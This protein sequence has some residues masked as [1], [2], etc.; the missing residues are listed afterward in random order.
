MMVDNV[1]PSLRTEV[2]EILYEPFANLGNAHLSVS[3]AAQ[4]LRGDFCTLD[5]FE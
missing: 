5:G 1:L 4:L 3:A 2:F